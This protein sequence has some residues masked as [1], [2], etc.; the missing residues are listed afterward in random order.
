MF[1]ELLCAGWAVT[2]RFVGWAIV[3]LP[4]FALGLLVAELLVTVLGLVL[5]LLCGF[6]ITCLF[7]VLPETFF[8]EELLVLFR[9]TVEL[10]LCIVPL[11]LAT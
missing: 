3:V 7:V 11:F 1:W 9:S 8:A 6:V 2:A 5:E 4:L 10:L